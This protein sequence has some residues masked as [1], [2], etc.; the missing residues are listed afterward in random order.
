LKEKFGL[1]M[2]RFFP[3]LFAEMIKKINVR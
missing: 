1:F 2:K 3:N